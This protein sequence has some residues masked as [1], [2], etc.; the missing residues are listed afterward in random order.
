METKTY[1]ELDIDYFGKYNPEQI[2]NVLYDLCGDNLKL[3]RFIGKALKKYADFKITAYAD[4]GWKWD[5]ENDGFDY[6]N[7][8]GDFAYCNEDMKKDIQEFEPDYDGWEM[9]EL[10][11][12]FAKFFGAFD[13]DKITLTNGKYIFLITDGDTVNFHIFDKKNMEDGKCDLWG[14]I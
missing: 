8:G 9:Y 6:D 13:W 3:K 4:Y 2:K 5:C 14:L 10:E 12:D 1:Q 7:R 11:Q